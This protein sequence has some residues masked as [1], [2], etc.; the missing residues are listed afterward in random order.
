ME[1]Q[2]GTNSP[3]SKINFYKATKEGLGTSA[4]ELLILSSFNAN[5]A[6]RKRS[7]ILHEPQPVSRKSI[8][9]W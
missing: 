9:K 5:A 6:V 4:A 7:T 1:N 3:D 2:T 8:P